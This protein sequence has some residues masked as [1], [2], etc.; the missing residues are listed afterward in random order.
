[1]SLPAWPGYLG[2]DAGLIAPRTESGRPGGKGTGGGDLGQKA[3]KT[4]NTQEEKVNQP[5]VCLV[6]V[7]T[8][9]KLREFGVGV[10]G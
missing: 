8:M 6:S 10:Y 7:C 1:M 3:D 5:K 4:H 2:D 9:L